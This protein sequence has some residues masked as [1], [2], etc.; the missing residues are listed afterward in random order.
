MKKEEV[1]SLARLAR[2]AITDEEAER[3]RSDMDNVLAYV[4]VISEIAGEEAAK[5]PGALRNVFRDDVVQHAPD[6]YTETL[7]AEVPHRQGRFLAVKKIL[8]VD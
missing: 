7:L 1:V 3:L 6:Q 8:N 5:E 2:I 4:S